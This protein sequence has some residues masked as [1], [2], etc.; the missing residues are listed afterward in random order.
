MPF[1]MQEM[2]LV[3]RSKDVSEIGVSFMPISKMRKKVFIHVIGALA[4][5]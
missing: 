2:N 1:I 5:G 4:K 3:F